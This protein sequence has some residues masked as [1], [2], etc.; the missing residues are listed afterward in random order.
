MPV[1][2]SRFFAAVGLTVLAVASTAHWLGSRSPAPELQASPAAQP[3]DGLAAMSGAGPS[4]STLLLPTEPGSSA[5][6]SHR[7]RR[8]HEGVLVGD[9]PFIDRLASASSIRGANDYRVRRAV[10]YARSLCSS[11]DPSG[12][13]ALP[14]PDPSRDWALEAIAKLCVGMGSL[15]VDESI[16]MIGEPESLSRVDRTLGRDA[17]IA[18]AEDWLATESDPVLLEEAALFAWEA[19]RAPS[20]ASMG[21]NPE[22]VGPSE[23]M[24]ALSDAVRLAA[25]GRPGDCGPSDWQTLAFCA[26][27][28]C[29]PGSSLHQA[30]RAHHGEQQMRLVDGYARWIRS[31]RSG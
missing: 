27:V 20:T 5:S 23:H 28:G 2:T 19:G 24:A 14:L 6:N 8:V 10:M 25:C 22:A 12:S 17:A 31:F 16:P 26:R 4:D 30:L 11:P 21:V 3:D 7:Q 9:G 18:A 13:L 15:E 29:A 1:R